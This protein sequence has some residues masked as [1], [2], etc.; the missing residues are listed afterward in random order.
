MNN[1]EL[2]LLLLRL[3][4]DYPAGYDF[5]VLRQAASVIREYM[6]SSNVA[7]N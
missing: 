3:E 7:G 4:N 1:D 5:R 6:E 2:E